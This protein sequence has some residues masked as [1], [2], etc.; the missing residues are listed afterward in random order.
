MRSVAIIPAR[1]GS[2]RIPRKNVKEFRGKPMISWSIRAAQESKCFDRIIVSTDDES[3]REIALLYGAEVPF[4]RPDELADDLT[5]TQAVIA[6]AVDYLGGVGDNYDYVCCIYATA[7]FA[8]SEDIKAGMQL[9]KECE[10]HEFVFAA[11]SFPYPIQRAITIDKSGRSRM[12]NPHEFSTRSQDLEECFHDAGQF[13]VAQASAWLIDTNILDSG[14]PL[15]LP[16]WRVQDID[17]M[18]DWK[19][20]EIMFDALC[21]S[22]EAAS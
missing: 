21:S 2:K 16:N 11:T 22:E 7:P 13:Y 19:R 18:E 10:Q 9:I 15:V 6:H 3:I 4:I 5:S 1:A 8:M 20:A 17:T 14:K 12:V